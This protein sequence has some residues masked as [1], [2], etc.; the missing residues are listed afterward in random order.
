MA[1]IVDARILYR[2][3]REPKEFYDFGER[4]HMEKHLS[5]LMKNGVVVR[6]NGKWG[7]AG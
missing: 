4:V 1:E 5:R 7:L 6:E 2:K 3:K